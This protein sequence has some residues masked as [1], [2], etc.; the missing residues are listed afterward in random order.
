VNAFF[1]G[2]AP[3]LVI[4]RNFPLA[5]SKGGNLDRVSRIMDS[6]PFGGGGILKLNSNPYYEISS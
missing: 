1:V 4:L 6:S 5:P 2:V 3:S